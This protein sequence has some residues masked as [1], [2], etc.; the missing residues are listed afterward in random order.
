[1][2]EKGQFSLFWI[3]DSQNT[4]G[5]TRC[6]ANTAFATPWFPSEIYRLPCLF[7]PYS[8]MHSVIYRSAVGMRKAFFAYGTIRFTVHASK[9]T[10][11]HPYRGSAPSRHLPASRETFV[12]CTVQAA[13]RASV[14]YNVPDEHDARRRG[15][16]S[17]QRTP[18][19]RTSIPYRLS[20]I[21]I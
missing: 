11:G 2:D 13:G 9:G 20:L 21:H 12:R 4:G 5:A 18:M 16:A 1:M 17:S 3:K 10:S 6:F 15:G 19:E 8:L 14:R 7:V